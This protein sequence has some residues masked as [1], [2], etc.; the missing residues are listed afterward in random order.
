MD[1]KVITIDGLNGT[2]KSTLAKGLAKAFNFSYL[3][4]GTIFRSL[5]YV[6]KQHNIEPHQTELIIYALQNMDFQVQTVEGETR[7]YVSGIDVTEEIKSDEYAVFAS[8]F[9]NNQFIQDSIRGVIRE[10]A[11]ETN[12]VVDGRD[13]GTVV[14]PNAD[15]KIV[16][17]ASLLAREERRSLEHN[18]PVLEVVEKFKEIDERAMQGFY[19]PPAD[20]KVID[21]TDMTRDEVLTVA[22]NFVSDKLQIPPVLIDDLNE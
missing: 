8:K 16:L 11:K 4:A 22:T 3:S 9:S 19:S 1:K 14:F 13:M 2:G 18:I 20:A 15:A 12:L 6:S 5:A 7:A 10:T 21:T 17:E